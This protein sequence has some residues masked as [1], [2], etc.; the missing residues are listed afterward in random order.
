MNIYCGCLCIYSHS[1]NLTS[2]QGSDT[3][4]QPINLTG[5]ILAWILVDY[6]QILIP[7]APV[8]LI[9]PDIAWQCCYVSRKIWCWEFLHLI[10]FSVSYFNKTPFHVI[11]I[12]YVFD[13]LFQL[14]LFANN[15]HLIEFSLYWIYLDLFSILGRLDGTWHY[16]FVFE[17]A[18]GFTVKQWLESCKIPEAPASVRCAIAALPH[19][20]HLPSSKRLAK[21]DWEGTFNIQ[22]GCCPLEMNII[23]TCSVSAFT[24]AIFLGK[25]RDMGPKLHNKVKKIINIYGLLIFVMSNQLE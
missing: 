18:F 8:H 5:V 19:S 2:P 14:P 13:I 23:L 24:A 4:L 3:L 16:S 20:H 7:V 21:A 17:L 15:L 12:F 25:G 9:H 1:K 11:Y 10:F 6:C 22:D